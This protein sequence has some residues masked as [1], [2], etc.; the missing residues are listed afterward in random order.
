MAG[1]VR[2]P[3]T[4]FGS[5]GVISA[6]TNFGQFGSLN[7]G[8]GLETTDIAT[9]M[10]LPAWTA[11]DQGAVYT[12]G[13][14]TA[15]LPLQEDNGWKYVHSYQ[16]GQVL[17]DG[18]PQ[19]QVAQVYQIGSRVQDA[20]NLGQIF[21]CLQANTVGG[22]L[23]VGASSA[24]WRWTNP[25][26]AV[27]SGSIPGGSI[28]KVGAA[29]STGPA[30]SQTL[31]AG[32]LSDDGTNVILASGGIQFPGGGVQTVP[33]N[34]VTSQADV[35]STRGYTTVFRNTTGKPLFVRVIG[36]GASIGFAIT[37]QAFSDN[38]ATPTLEVDSVSIGVAGQ[39]TVGTISVFFIVLPNNY[40]KVTAASVSLAKWIEWN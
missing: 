4:V 22:T 6:P 35:T 21:S 12:G 2:Q 13:G 27:V 31:V 19:W 5:A 15:V 39:E 36:S 29:A 30:S 20:S 18:I 33:A 28:P 26:L 16:I 37:Q 9:I 11:G 10:A 8:G 23:P 24:A 32:L 40:Y 3:F 34:P 38:S 7:G 17:Q 1:Q 25:P 14:A